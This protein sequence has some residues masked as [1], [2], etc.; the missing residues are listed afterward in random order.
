M[1]LSAA[2]GAG[3]CPDSG[4]VEVLNYCMT[5]REGAGWRYTS[6]IIRALDRCSDV[7]VRNIGTRLA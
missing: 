3:S 1:Y 4:L 5:G 6:K 7:D 2:G